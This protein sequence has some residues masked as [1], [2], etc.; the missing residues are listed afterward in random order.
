MTEVER[1]ALRTPLRIRIA[2]GMVAAAPRPVHRPTILDTDFWEQIRD[3]Q[4]DRLAA[5]FVLCMF[6]LP[7]LVFLLVAV[8]LLLNGA[9]R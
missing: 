1:A 8:L 5:G 3:E 6:A 2:V 7:P 4:L 9:G